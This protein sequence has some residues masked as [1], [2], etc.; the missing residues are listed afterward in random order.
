MKAQKLTNTGCRITKNGTV[1]TS[2]E[3]DAVISANF[4]GN[5]YKS[6]GTYYFFQRKQ[7]THFIYLAE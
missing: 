3:P 1:L 2:I 6:N 5:A 7:G 4:M